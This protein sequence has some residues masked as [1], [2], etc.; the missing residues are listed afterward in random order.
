MD[1]RTFLRLM[2]AGG[3]M[4]AHAR[5]S[6][7]IPRGARRGGGPQ[8][9]YGRWIVQ[10]GLPA[11][12]YELDQDAEP[13]AEWDPFLSPKTRRNWVMVGNRAIRLQ[14]AN[15]GT[16]ALFDEGDGLRW[17]VAPE[18]SGTGVSVLDDDAGKTWGSEFAMRAGERPPRRTFGPTWFEVED[19]YRG[20]TLVRTILCPEGETP[21]VLV[22]V[23]LRLARGARGARTVRHVEQ[24]RL[25]PRFLNL[26][27][28]AALRTSRGDAAVTYD[29]VASDAGLVAAEQFAAPTDPPPAGPAAAFLIGPPATLAL[30]RLGKTDGDASH[31]LDGGPYP[32]LEIATDVRLRPG[33]RSELWF[34]FGRLDATPVTQ[35]ARLFASSRRALAARLPRGAA[36][37]AP[38]AACELAWH[39]A[40]LTGGLAVDRVIGGHS[41]D[42]ASTYSYLMGFNGAAR[43]P[44]QH[45]LPLVYV[46]PDVALSV[47]RNTCA[48][49]QPNGDLPYALDGAKKPTNIVF[50]PSDGN[51]WAL[52]L[53]AEY[54]AATGDLA[55]FDAP[56]A[57]HPMHAT[58]AVPL[59]EHLR[60]Q[61]RFF[62]DEVGRG[63]RNHVRILNADWNDTAIADSGVDRTVMVAQGS[64]V[65]N[66]AMASWVLAVFAGLATRLGETALAA[67]ATAQADE[68]RGLVA[69]AWNGKWFHRAYAPGV[70]PVGDDDCWLEVQPWAI[71]C[72]AADATQAASLVA[73]IDQGHR[74]GSPVGARLRWPAPPDRVAAGTWGDATLGGSWFAI[75]MTLVWAASRGAPDVAW[76]A[77][78]RMTLGAH[79][80]AYPSIWEGTLSGP[81]SWNAPESTRP[82][83]TWSAAPAFAMQAFPV[84]NMH[85]HAQPLFAYL[86]LLGVEPTTEGALAVGRG[87]EFR[88]RVLQVAR[89][90]HGSLRPSGPVVVETSRGVV[91]GGPGRVRW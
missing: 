17:L 27:E 30:E 49:A 67:E 6:V 86:R 89:S 57:Y 38:E 42:Q 5:P 26:F 83:R 63:E 32:V 41:L 9:L 55:A 64:S 40:L 28:T 46:E 4:M 34:R 21:W 72:G 2:A 3:V 45:A 18:P 70:D 39:G 54:A 47:L 51:L 29:V 69:Q 80:A 16:V 77:W 11:F 58:A 62:V 56:L 8:S 50:R 10:D 74:A 79:T 13:A 61:F 7:A 82:G 43:D 24:W 66:S 73:L 36:P 91:R 33:G 71:L 25:R 81:D 48:W 65:L 90:G 78:R 44:L 12:R 88:S 20:L 53:A 76:D 60:R 59:R 35:P 23:Q 87:G 68:L 1:R 15:D 31:R 84:N 19:A 75:D 14:A 22:R 85:S 37:K 52:W